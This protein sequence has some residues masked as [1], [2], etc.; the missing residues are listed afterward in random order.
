MP[1]LSEVI[2][3]SDDLR[4]PPYKGDP[5]P[6]AGHCYVVSEA[7][8]HRLLAM[9]FQPENVK[10]MFLRV[11]GQPHWYVAARLARGGEWSYLDGTWEQFGTPPDWTKGKGKGF[12]T[13]QPSKRART[14]MQRMGWA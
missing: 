5:N 2:A 7:I 6:F 11:N 12:L 3:A 13:K 4:R 9:G 1:L 10:P 14:F 8:Y